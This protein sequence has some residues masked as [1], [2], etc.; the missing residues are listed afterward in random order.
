MGES[1]PR[2]Q[3]RK[4]EHDKVFSEIVAA[5]SAQIDGKVSAGRAW[6]SLKAT[7]RLEGSSKRLEQ[8]CKRPSAP[9]LGLCSVQVFMA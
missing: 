7:K 4:E 5:F 8:E 6:R 3:G 1:V 9:I 2:A